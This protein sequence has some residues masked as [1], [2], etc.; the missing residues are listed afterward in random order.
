MTTTYDIGDGVSLRHTIYDG[1]GELS[2]AD[3]TLVVTDPDGGQATVP[4]TSSSTGVYESEEIVVDKAGVW[5]FVWTAVGLVNDVTAGEFAVIPASASTGWATRND[6]LDITGELVSL[7]QLRQAQAVIE[8]HVGRSAAADEAAGARDLYWL[9]QAVCWQAAW[10]KD[11]PGYTQR[12]Q[13]ARVQQDGTGYD[14][15]TS[16]AVVLAPLAIR[17]IRNLSWIGGNRVL[18]LA[19]R[20]V[21][22]PA[23][24]NVETSDELHPW[25]PL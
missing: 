15:D 21:P 11:Q 3:V 19:D 20:T 22:A 14:Y 12:H 9:K 10:Q 5:S 24:F 17:A 2:D 1:D 8:L 23:A 4:T 13:V 16:V 6:V 25:R 7:G 18:S